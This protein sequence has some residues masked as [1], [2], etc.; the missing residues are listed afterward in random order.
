M[1]PRVRASPVRALTL[2]GLT[3]CFVGQSWL[4]YADAP[5]PVQLEGEALRGAAVWHHENCQACHQIHGYGGFLG[6]DLTNF[7]RRFPDGGAVLEAWLLSGPGAMPRFDHLPA[8]DRQALWA[9]LE[10]VDRTGVGQARA[11]DWWEFQ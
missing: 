4:I 5:G 10:A 1:P 6:P 11:L 7:A 2:A 9:W 3:A 8:D